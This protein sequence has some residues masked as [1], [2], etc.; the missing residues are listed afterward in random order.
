MF[1]VDQSNVNRSLEA[2]NRVLS[3]MLPTARR[4]T[5]LIREVDTLTDLKRIIPPDP[6]TGKVA[7]VLDGTHMPVDRSGDRNRRRADHSG[8]KMFTFNTDIL[9]DTRKRI[10]WISETVPGITHDL[11]LPK[12]DP[13]DLGILTRIMSRHDTPES[14][15]CRPNPDRLTGGLAEGELTLNEEINGTRIRHREKVIRGLK[16]EDSAILSGLRLYHNFVR[17]HLGLPDHTTPAEAAGI[18]VQGDNKFQ[19][20]IQ[21]AVQSD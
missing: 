16:K 7:V 5:W 15:R 19:T 12:E 9:T 13:P 2:S 20:P 17:G 3:E 6:A 18:H 4:M 14:A 10:L 1:G 8:K 11:T 21:A